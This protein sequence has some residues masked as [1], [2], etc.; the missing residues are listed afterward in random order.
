M[1][2][3]LIVTWVVMLGFVCYSILGRM[4]RSIK[5]LRSKEVT[6]SASPNKARDAIAL[7]KSLA[8]VDKVFLCN[9][10]FAD[11]FIKRAQCIVQQHP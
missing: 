2:I 5:T 9:P 10:A 11:T 8:A 1:L 4:Q 7:C 3:A 6:P